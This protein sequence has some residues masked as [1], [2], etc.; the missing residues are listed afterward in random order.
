MLYN[1]SAVATVSLVQGMVLVL[2]HFASSEL[3]VL[4]FTTART[5]TGLVRLVAIQLAMVLGIEQARERGGGR[6]ESLLRLHRF[7]LRLAGGVAGGLAGLIAV[8]GGDLLTLWTHGR[9]PYHP[10]LFLL[11]LAMVVVGIPARAAAQLFVYT[12]RPRLPAMSQTLAAV[13]ALGLAGLLVPAWGAQGAVVAL[14]TAELSAVAGWLGSAVARDLGQGRLKLWFEGGGPALAAFVL[15]GAVAWL[16][17]QGFGGLEWWRMIAV[18]GAWLVL[19]AVPAFYIIVPADQRRR[20]FV[21]GGE[22]R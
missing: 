11:L 19:A 9:V 6:H 21:R 14:L 18:V 17:H 3:A 2:S 16:L 15:G 13:V 10:D 7:T 1:L 4:L 5:I 22:P 20:L 8:F 12:N